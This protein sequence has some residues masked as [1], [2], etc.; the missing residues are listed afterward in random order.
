MRRLIAG[1]AALTAISFSP[2]AHAQLLPPVPTLTGTLTTLGSSGPTEFGAPVTLTS[3]TSTLL[4]APVPTG[5]VDFL[6]GAT[7][8][9]AD[10]PVV[11]GAA[12]CV[13]DDLPASPLVGH[14]VEARYEAA[15]A[16]P[17]SGT[18]LQKVTGIVAALPRTITYGDPPPTDLVATVM[19]A[20][21]V[22]F[23]SVTGTA[24]AAGTYDDAIVCSAGG[25]EELGLLLKFVPADLTIARA[26][27]TLTADP[28]TMTAGQALPAVTATATGLV[29]GD[30]LATAVSNLRCSGPSPLPAGAGTYAGALTCLADSLNYAVTFVPGTLTVLA[31]VL[32]GTGTG[33]GGGAGGGGSTTGGSTSTTTNTTNNVTNVGISGGGGGT[34]APRAP[35]V[36]LLT[37]KL[38]RTKRVRLK[39]SSTGPVGRLELTLKRDG[40]SVARGSLGV[41]SGP[42]GATLKAARKLKK[43]LYTL[44]ATWFDGLGRPGKKRFSVRVR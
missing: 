21:G 14:L 36:S 13:T 11:A 12:Q 3:A 16:L 35:T 38:K 31:P 32:D 7:V 33:T 30:T 37:K 41:L 40:K 9:C 44:Q 42:G 5:T 4:G 19:G 25:L 28:V 22:P 1:L 6:T 8:L 20:T 24:K 27:L 29:A 18:V 17:S 26:P 23:C 39:L 34:A 10:V 2:A 43:G 15:G